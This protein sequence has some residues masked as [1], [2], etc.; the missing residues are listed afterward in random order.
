MKRRQ[1]A[2]P[3]V[4]PPPVP[5]AFIPGAGPGACAGLC[6][7]ETERWMRRAVRAEPEHYTD[8][9]EVCMTLLAESC[10]QAF[11]WYEWDGDDANIPEQLFDEAFSVFQWWGAA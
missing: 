3:T 7:T 2:G 9:Y 11:D 6:M 5:R 1:L 8:C 10:A 4:A